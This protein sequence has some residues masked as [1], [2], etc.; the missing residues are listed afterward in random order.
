ML[1]KTE[2]VD[3]GQRLD[4]LTEG[5]DETS[6]SIQRRHSAEIQRSPGQKLRRIRSL[7]GRAQSY[8]QL[9]MVEHDYPEFEE[10]QEFKDDS[11]T[12][13]KPVKV[14]KRKHSLPSKIVKSVTS[15]STSPVR[16]SAPVLSRKADNAYNRRSLQA[17]ETVI[18]NSSSGTDECFSPAST[19]QSSPKLYRVSSAR[20][21]AKLSTKV[22]VAPRPSR[23]SQ[24]LYRNNAYNTLPCRKSSAGSP[25]YIC[26][27]SL[28]DVS[29]IPDSLW[30]ECSLHSEGSTIFRISSATGQI[31][32]VHRTVPLKKLNAGS[33]ETLN[34]PNNG[35]PLRRAHQLSIHRCSSSEEPDLGMIM[36]LT[37]EPR[38][39]SVCM[40]PP[41]SPSYVSTP[42]RNSII[43]QS[44]ETTV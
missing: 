35:S 19:P 30:D 13:S 12:I 40:E 26:D 44:I 24:T 8:I 10:V 31:E 39:L 41:N 23:S 21:I 16:P 14:R 17:L 33:I 20:S 3:I 36:N 22:L 34:S 15:L 32:K 2:R 7:E 11:E 37:E 27:D 1:L 4:S 38:P 5:I 42:K 29:S 28:S 9:P 18:D 25:S 6:H 43:L